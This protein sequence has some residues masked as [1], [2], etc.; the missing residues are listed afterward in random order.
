[1]ATNKN[2]QV[3]AQNT[4]NN[5]ATI[6]TIKNIDKKQCTVIY[7]GIEYNGKLLNTNPSTHLKFNGFDII[8]P[9]KIII[10]GVQVSTKISGQ[11]NFINWL[12]TL[13][14]KQFTFDKATRATSTKTSTKTS[15][16]N[17]INNN[18]QLKQEYNTLKQQLDNATTMFDA[19]MQAQQ[20]AMQQ[21][22]ATTQLQNILKSGILTSE[23]LQ[24]I[25]QGGEKWKV[26]QH[27]QTALTIL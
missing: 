17:Y 20:Q 11:A 15:L 13:Q 16:L 3:Q 21:A 12:T 5:S 26:K 25:L 14:G 22:Q 24:A 9:S 18:E 27:K 23:Q 10:D 6:Y 8:L 4:L 7:E 2:E 1:M 19:F